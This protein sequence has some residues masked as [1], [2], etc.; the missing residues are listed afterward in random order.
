M[1]I[2]LGFRSVIRTY[3]LRLPGDCSSAVCMFVDGC[4]IGKKKSSR[5]ECKFVFLLGRI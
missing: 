5:R 1:L 4:N 3:Y 2:P